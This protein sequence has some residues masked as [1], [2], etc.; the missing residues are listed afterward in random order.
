V[1]GDTLYVGA[2]NAGFHAFDVSGEL[3]GDL[4]AQGRKLAEVYTADGQG[5]LANQP[6]TWGVVVNRKDGLA[7]VNDLNN[8]LWIVRMEPKPPV[9]P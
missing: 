8:G 3:R 9:V 1:A 4:G 6:M 7:Y 2:Y 5:K